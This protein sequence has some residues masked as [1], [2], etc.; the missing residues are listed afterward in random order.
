MKNSS[1][2]S[3]RHVLMLVPGFPEDE[4]DTTCI[5]A[6]QSYVLALSRVHP[7]CKLSV[8]SF[9]Y[10]FTKEP[11]KW[12]GITVYPC[13]GANRGKIRR[14]W[15]WFTA[16]RYI[17]SI[18]R[19]P[20]DIIHSFWLEETTL[21]GQWTNYLINVP[22]VASLMGQDA[23]PQNSFLHRLNFNRLTTSAGSEHAV[24]TLG[25]NGR[26][27]A[28]IPIG[29]NKSDFPEEKKHREIDILGVGALTKLKNYSLFIDLIHELKEDFP[30]INSAILGGGPE[31]QQLES[32][33]S[34]YGLDRNVL[35]TGQLD[36]PAVLRY[37]ANSRI[38]L[39]T[40]SYESQG[41][42][43]NEALYSGLSVVCFPVGNAASPKTHHC[44]DRREML[45]TLRKLLNSTADTN[46]IMLNSI[47]ETVAAFWD[48]Y[49]RA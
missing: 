49:K 31:Q 44:K 15:T 48:L 32:A 22:H 45:Q 16:I 9:Q 38:L 42:V 25:K 6:L 34:K 20:I 37:M 7:Q 24:E 2:D 46:P 13:G 4:S 18:Q 30:G 21:V 17:L 14:L 26:I 1:V 27:D 23:D 39:H 29:L 36:R 8:I 33:I 5:P 47:D 19:V 40:S 43:F 41:Y 3:P 12:N 28:V 35:L 11:Y 10:P